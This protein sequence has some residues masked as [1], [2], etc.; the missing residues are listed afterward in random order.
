MTVDSRS[1][2]GPAA[3]AGTSTGLAGVVAIIPAHN[4]ERFIGSVVLRT[5]PF[6]EKVIVVDDGSQDETARIAEAAGAVV[7]RLAENQGKGAALNAG[8][9]KAQELSPR[10]VVTIDGDGQH[11]PGDL[12]QVAAPVAEGRADI[13]VGSRYL[14]PGGGVP[15]HR[16]WGHWFFTRLTNACSGVSVTDSQSGFRAFSPAAL[17]TIM[18]S[19]KGFT[20]ES[21]MQFLARDRGL[22]M[23]EVPVVI[24]YRDP[25]KR[26]VF[27]HGA[28]VMSGILSLIERRRPLLFFG[29]PGAILILAGLAGGLWVVDIYS[30]FQTLAVGYALI[31]VMLVLLGIFCVFTGIILHSVQALLTELRQLIERR[32]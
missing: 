12:T 2:P 25:P 9:R 14:E 4:E 19:S 31:V 20:V 24:R 29:L 11:H 16:V 22:R 3:A 26:N 10:V 30:R 15:T 6:C 27:A 1:D 32:E 28:E 23:V 18:F 21:E 8:F 17:Q 7:V 13:V 5:R